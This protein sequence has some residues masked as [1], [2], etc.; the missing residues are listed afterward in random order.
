M[1]VRY[2]DNVGSVERLDF[3]ATKSLSG[4]LYSSE[5][6]KPYPPIHSVIH[7]RS[8]SVVP[9]RISDGRRNESTVS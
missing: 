1:T 8:E 6:C 5:V 9:H 2:F 7:S 3:S 4:A